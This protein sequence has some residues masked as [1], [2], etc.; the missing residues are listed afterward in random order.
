MNYADYSVRKVMM[1]RS[2]N[3][4]SMSCD[5][6]RRG[7]LIA[8]VIDEGRGGCWDFEW[9]DAREEEV[10]AQ[11][12]LTLPQYEFDGTMME[13]DIE[14]F[15]NLLVERAEEMKHFA[16]VLKSA[17]VYTLDGAVKQVKAE[18]AQRAKLTATIRLAHPEA[19]ILETPDA[20]AA[21]VAARKAN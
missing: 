14:L 20:V 17:I 19:V 13:L 16:K 4:Y 9:L 2:R 1:A 7:K 5:L 21:A 18:A 8:R 15:V 11:H 12:C 10:L 6:L 3:G